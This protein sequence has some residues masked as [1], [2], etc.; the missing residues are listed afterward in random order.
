MQEVTDATIEFVGDGGTGI[1]RKASARYLRLG[2]VPSEYN[3]VFDDKDRIIVLPVGSRIWAFLI[4]FSGSLWRSWGLLEDAECLRTR[5]QIHSPFQASDKLGEVRAKGCQTPEIRSFVP[6]AVQTSNPP[7]R[8]LSGLDLTLLFKEGRPVRPGRMSDQP[9]PS[10]Q[11]DSP[12]GHWYLHKLFLKLPNLL[13][14]IS[15]GSGSSV[16]T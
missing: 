13:R 9:S 2:I 8:R 12:R 7:A 14:R 1:R 6:P 11:L 16:R 10:L 5:L 3:A 4:V 15:L